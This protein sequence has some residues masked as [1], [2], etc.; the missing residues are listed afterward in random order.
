MNDVLL[1]IVLDES[2][3]ELDVALDGSADIVLDISLD[4]IINNTDTANVQSSYT[5]GEN[6]SSGNL[7]MLGADGKVYRND[8]TLEAN[9]GRAIGFAVQAV[10]TNQPVTIVTEGQYSQAGF[11]LSTGAVY[12]AGPAGSIISTPPASAIYQQVGVARAANILLIEI[13]EPIIQS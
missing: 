11:G 9:Y 8:P 4:S 6:L 10:L 1:D 2:A 7:V 13:Q 12:Y 3:M 5:A